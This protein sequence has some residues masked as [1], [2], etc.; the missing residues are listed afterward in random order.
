MLVCHQCGKENQETYRFCL[1]CGAEVSPPDA[2]VPSAPPLFDQ[3][4]GQSHGQSYGYGSFKSGSA[5]SGGTVSTMQGG[6]GSGKRCPQCGA[7]V[8]GFAFCGQCGTRVVS[9]PKSAPRGLTPPAAPAAARAPRGKLIL[10]RPD[11][12]E[13]GSS[14]LF[15]GS[16]LIGRGTGALF[17][18]DNYLSPRHAELV[19]GQAGLVVRDTG[20]LNGL[21]VKLA[22]EEELV[23]RDVFRI[24]QELMRFDVIHDSVPLEDGTHLMGSPNPGYWGRLTLIIGR[25]QDG[26]AFPLSGEA[27]ILGRERGDIL[28]PEDGY[29]SGAHARLSKRGERYF[30]GDMNSSNGTFVRVRSE[31]TIRSGTYLLIGQQLFRVQYS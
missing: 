8:T 21:F 14:P 5:A 12:S 1:G 23:D 11:G 2:T 25:G 4:H 18:A 7:D 17:D 9:S 29:V 10:I 6:A 22:E 27:I 24:G 16:N 13:G 15:D 19:L 31:R 26:S 28:F 3:S 30:L 20:S